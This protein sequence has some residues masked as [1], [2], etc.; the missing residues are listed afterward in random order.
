MSTG[1]LTHSQALPLVATPKRILRMRNQLK[2]AEVS[3]RFTKRAADCLRAIP[4]SPNQCSIPGHYIPATQRGD[5]AV[6]QA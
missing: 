6:T 4:R 2:L 3:G 1:A 5:H